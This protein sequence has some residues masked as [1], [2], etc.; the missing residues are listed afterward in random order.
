[1]R[2]K[3]RVH[4]YHG[5]ML[6]IT[7]ERWNRVVWNRL[8]RARFSVRSVR[9]VRLRRDRAVGSATLEFA[10]TIGIALLM[11]LTVIDFGRIAGIH[12]AAVTASRE[13]ARY[14]SAIG[15]AASGLERYR[16]CAGILAAAR[17]FTW[18]LL[19]P[20]DADVDVE[21]DRGPGTAAFAA[22]ELDSPPA[23]AVIAS[24]DR[25]IVKVAIT[26]EAISPV[27]LIVGPMTISTIGRRTIV[28]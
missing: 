17:N 10:L 15:V 6:T 11:L 12:V 5:L 25:V 23:A 13:A 26:F 19:D 16:D 2:Q 27:G 7:N 3:S 1:M 24:L 8:G 18:P 9:S 28:K 4:R 21:Y 20:D 22:C 14:G